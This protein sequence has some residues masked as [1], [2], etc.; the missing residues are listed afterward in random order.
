VTKRP[1]IIDTDP[2]LDDALAI[3]LAFASPEL[4]VLGLT[5]VA[6][7]VPLDATTANA[8]RLCELG[9]R[10]DVPV[11]AGCDRPLAR[12][13]VT[14]LRHG[15]T[16]LDGA[17]L[18]A[19]IMAP[20]KEHAVRW[21]IDRIMGAAPGTI[22]LCAI[23]PLTNV[24]TALT[25]EPRLGRRL[26]GIVIMGG[27][28]RVSGNIT[29]EAEFNIY[30]DP[31]AADIVFACGGDLTLVPLDLTQQVLVTAAIVGRI[32]AIGTAVARAAAGMLEFYNSKPEHALG[33]PLHDP[34]VI[35]HL[36]DPTLFSGPFVNVAVELGEGPTL[37]KT[38][39]DWDGGSGRPNNARVLTVADSE[40]F[41]D[42]L[43]GRLAR[44]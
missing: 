23:G 41:F 11:F 28:G 34:C 33:S 3:L 38:I 13:A 32:R 25:E 30:V 43:T 39:I 14:T 31:H 22:T 24:A 16:G 8:L 26:A 27:A 40:G 7:N 4:E 36:L 2:G 1:I 44:L 35:A 29:P 37:G 12:P 21:L 10:G 19:P 9:R 18:P 15:E 20:R 17:D 5:A 6:G 42:L